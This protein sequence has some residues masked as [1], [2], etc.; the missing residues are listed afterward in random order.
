MGSG[1]LR[2]YRLGRGVLGRA[3]VALATLAVVGVVGGSGHPLANPAGRSTASAHPAAPAPPAPAPG[4]STPVSR[5]PG[6]RESAA[7][8]SAT[9]VGDGSMQAFGEQVFALVAGNRV[10]LLGRIETPSEA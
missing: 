3:P 10:R 9:A 2:S 7:S 1:L 4:T 6:S 8:P 5:A